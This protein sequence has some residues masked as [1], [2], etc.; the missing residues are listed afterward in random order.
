MV[1][2]GKKI[3]TEYVKFSKQLK[4]HFKN[5]SDLNGKKMLDINTDMNWVMC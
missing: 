1:L 3:Y 5:T 4:E 2:L